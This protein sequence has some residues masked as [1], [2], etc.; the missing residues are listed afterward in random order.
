[1]L[2]QQAPLDGPFLKRCLP[3]AR[4]IVEHIEFEDYSSATKLPTETITHFIG[5]KLEIVCNPH[6][7]DKKPV[8]ANK[9][10]EGLIL[11]RLLSLE[12]SG[13]GRQPITHNPRRSG[14]CAIG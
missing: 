6:P 5:G 12:L 8:A 14:R 10:H 13:T 9:F 11:H 4:R 2:S 1:M 7:A 3:R